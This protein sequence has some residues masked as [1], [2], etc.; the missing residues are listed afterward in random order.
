MHALAPDGRLLAGMDA[1]RA[2]YSAVGLGWL[3]APTRLPLARR[4]AERAYLAMPNRYAISRR[5]RL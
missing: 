5:L 4:L 1:I 3:L 2:A